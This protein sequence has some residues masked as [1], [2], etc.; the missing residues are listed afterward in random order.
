MLVHHE[1]GTITP[2]SGTGTATIGNNGS[3]MMMQ[4]FLKPTTATTT[5]DFKLTDRNSLDIF[6]RTKET[7]TYNELKVGLIVYGQLTLTISNASADEAFTYLLT[8]RES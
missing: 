7:G 8:Y 5:H 2:S 1:T 3:Q 4:I 6:E